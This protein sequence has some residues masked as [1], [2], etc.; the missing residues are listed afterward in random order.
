MPNYRADLYAAGDRFTGTERFDAS[1]PVEAVEIARQWVVA[2]GLDHAVL[3]A[4]DGTGLT[5][6]VAQVGAA[7]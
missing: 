4:C 7:R 3:Y 5:Q 2:L 6:H 1:N